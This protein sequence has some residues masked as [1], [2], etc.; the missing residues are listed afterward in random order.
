MTKPIYPNGYHAI[1]PILRVDS[2][3]EA[4]E[5]FA[6]A[7]GAVEDFRREAEGQVLLVVVRM[8]DCRLML[9]DRSNAPD[10]PT[11]G[12]PRGANLI[13]KLYVADVDAVFQSAI[14]LGA[15]EK[16][17]IADQYFGE[18]SGMLTDPFGF[19]WQIAQFKEEL[20]HDVIEQ[21]MRDA[22]KQ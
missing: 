20:P 13:L 9:F 12:D 14:G 10:Q 11:G 18:R 1:M 19:T 7:F 5:F 21:R 17:P 22:L 8:G 16:E 3:P 2:A 6:A 4:L 15:A